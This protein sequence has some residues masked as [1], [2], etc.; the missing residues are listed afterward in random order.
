MNLIKKNCFNI[1]LLLITCSIFAS[2]TFYLKSFYGFIFF[3]FFLI[4]FL[5]Y[6]CNSI[7]LLRNF[8]QKYK[9]Q[10][11]I[12]C[13]LNISFHSSYFTS[14][15][16]IDLFGYE[17]LRVKYISTIINVFFF[18]TLLF[19]FYSTKINYNKLI[20]AIIFPGIIYALYIFIIIF[21]EQE[22]TY[23]NLYF[24][25]N[26]R[27]VGMFMVVT[28]GFF[29]GYLCLDEK[30]FNKKY[31]ILI[32]SLPIT[33]IIFFGGRGTFFSLIIMI[34]SALIILIIKK[35]NINNLLTICFF[36]FVLAII[37]NQLTFFSFNIP[38]TDKM[39]FQRYDLSDRHEIWEYAINKIIDKPF[40]GYGPN[41]FA[42]IAFNDI[43]YVSGYYSQPH[44]FII[45]FLF[46]YGIIGTLLFLLLIGLLAVSCIKKLFKTKNNN[47]MFSGLPIISLTTVGMVDGSYYHPTIVFYLCLAFSLITSESIKD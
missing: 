15:L 21:S 44:N 13:L 37:I 31:S 36:S 8:L 46:E 34:L 11:I 12:F 2:D 18:I 38:T 39:T 3:E 5:L 23:K 32:L 40:L 14:P 42:I 1:F 6:N 16:T 4:I 30:N 45:Q 27:Q 9:F 19:Y 43:N 26:I 35:Q 24:F 10:S 28:T 25:N 20:L 22:L 7:A 41:G 17:W 29:L 33:L 47:L